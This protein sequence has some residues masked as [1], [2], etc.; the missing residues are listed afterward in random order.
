VLA[1]VVYYQASEEAAEDVANASFGNRASAC[2][3]SIRSY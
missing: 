1:V 2:R 3:A